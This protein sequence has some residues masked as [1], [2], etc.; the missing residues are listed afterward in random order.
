MPTVVAD[1]ADGEPDI[2]EA[3]ASVVEIDDQGVGA[4]IEV[5]RGAVDL[6]DHARGRQ[7][8][9]ARPTFDS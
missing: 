5:Q 2:D 1:V 4:G 3:R 9:A 7:R 6:A 8:A